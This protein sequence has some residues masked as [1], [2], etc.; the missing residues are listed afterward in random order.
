VICSSKTFITTY[1]TAWCHNPEDNKPNFHCN[2][3]LKSCMFNICCATGLNSLQCFMQ[4]DS[5]LEL[6]TMCSPKC[7][8][9]NKFVSN[10]CQIAATV[11]YFS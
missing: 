1:K 10:A 7:P 6:Y 4:P 11:L 8:N 2:K 5:V 3:N 9:F